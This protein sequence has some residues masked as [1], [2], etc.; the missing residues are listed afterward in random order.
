MTANRVRRAAL[1]AA[2]V[3]A[4]MAAAGSATAQPVSLNYESLSAMEEPLA[5]EGGDVTVTLTGLVDARVSVDN[6]DSNETDTGS[7]ANFQVSAR[8]QL[9]NRWRVDLSYFGQHASDPTTLFG[10]G[11][12]YTG[13]AALS[14][15]GYWGRVSGGNVSGIVRKL[16]R[17]LRGAGNAALGLDNFLG[18]LED[19]S[20]GYTG[21]FGPWVV[22]AVVD[23]DGNLDLGTAFQRPAGVRDWRLALRAAEGVFGS[24][25][26]R[27][28][29]TKGLGLVG[30][31][32]YGSTTLDAGAGY[33]RLSSS[34]P[35]LDRRYVS[36]GM[37]T[38]AGMLSLS[39]E[40]HA[41]RIEGKDEASVALGGQYDIARGLSA[42]LGLNHAKARV[43]FDGVPLLDIEETKSVLSLRYSF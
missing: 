42:N 19:L 13:N 23:E 8:T 24:S 41:G 29:D 32:I 30:E 16:T 3:A 21:R 14:V 34:G 12:G 17:R 35:D 37:H 4:G 40:G 6:E 33:E 11:E 31:V 25:G 36:V 28:F 39:L 7:I 43:S 15:G 18:E 10:T 27:R 38:K 2:V 1:P 26:G 20:A 5:V 9:P 22:G